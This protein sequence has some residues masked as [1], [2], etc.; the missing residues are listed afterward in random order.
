MFAFIA[1]ALLV[2][3]SGASGPHTTSAATGHPSG[4]TIIYG[5][6]RQAPLPE[7]IATAW[8]DALELARQNPAAIGYPKPD[9]VARELVLPVTSA[10]GAAMA[11]A[12][13]PRSA[14]AAVQ[15]RTEQAT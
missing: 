7:D 14:V 4:L 9:R 15:R 6:P 3:A 10:A 1:A 5:L 8:S 13:S 12:W 11:R 2:F